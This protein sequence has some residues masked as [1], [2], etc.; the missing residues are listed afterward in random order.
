[1]YIQNLLLNAKSGV[2]FWFFLLGEEDGLST[3]YMRR[4]GR[5]GEGRGGEEKGEGM[6]YSM[7]EEMME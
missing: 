3:T 2:G 4:M 5:G 7:G 6:I 1:M